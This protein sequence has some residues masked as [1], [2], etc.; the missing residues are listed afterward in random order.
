MRGQVL[1][2]SVQRNGG[3][4]TGTDGVRYN[5]FG[6]E[7]K[8]DTPPVRGMMVD[9]DVNGNEAIGIYE[10]LG[11]AGGSTPGAKSKPAVTLWNMFLGGLGAHKF[12]MGSWGWGIVY[13][14]TCWLWVPFL[15]SLVEVIHVILMSDDEF[16]VKVAEFQSK[17][18][19]AFSFFW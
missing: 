6:L 5:F 15:V 10:A 7:W 8:A 13:L 19:G 18:P 4:I 14:A 17:G 9:F 2:Y 3:I 12:Y 11:T 16:Q 1:D